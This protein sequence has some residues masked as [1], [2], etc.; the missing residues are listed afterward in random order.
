MSSV[1]T[2]LVLF[3]VSVFLWYRPVSKSIFP[4]APGLKQAPGHLSGLFKAK[5]Y[6]EDP[7]FYNKKY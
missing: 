2:T 3:S 4:N 1:F 5:T 6:D 7:S